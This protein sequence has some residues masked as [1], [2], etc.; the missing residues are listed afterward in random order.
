M[1][2][3]LTYGCDARQ[4]HENRSLSRLGQGMLSFRPQH[5][6]PSVSCLPRLSSGCP[7]PNDHSVQLTS[8]FTHSINAREHCRRVKVRYIYSIESNKDSQHPKGLVEDAIC[9]IRTLVMVD[10]QMNLCQRICEATH[11]F[12]LLQGK[13]GGVSSLCK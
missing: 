10:S 3:N 1:R 2:W 12:V 9:G 5:C 7:V 11:V 8:N 13:W 4:E 6:S